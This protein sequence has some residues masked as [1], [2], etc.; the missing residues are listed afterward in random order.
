VTAFDASV[1]VR[2]VRSAAARL[3]EQSDELSRLDAIAGDG[4]H[5]VNMSTAFA[6][7]VRR[8]ADQPPKTAADVFR[9]TSAAFQETVGGA[10][11]ALL[12][13][14]FG[15][16]A[17]G[18]D[19]NDAPG[20]AEVAIALRQGADRLIRVGRTELGQKTMVDAL[21]PAVE[22]CVTAT[23]EGAELAPAFAAAAT[24]ARDGADATATMKPA[25]G[26]ARYAAER[27]L[28]TPDPGAMTIAHIFAAWAEVLNTE[29]AA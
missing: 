29:V 9:S 23:E 17:R 13:A 28:G 6:D 24:A 5:G 4:D 7:A 8:I 14:F 27:S 10:S 2:L 18:L 19:G 16:V 22:A 25:A 11:G 15:A 20:P 1:A 26:R 3:A 12:G 21:V